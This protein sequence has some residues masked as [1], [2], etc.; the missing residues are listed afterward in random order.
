MA[1]SGYAWGAFS[2]G[3]L[4]SVACTFFLG[5][6]YEDIGVVTEEEFRGMGLSVACAGALCGD[7]INR[8]HRPSWT[9]WADNQASIRVAEKLGFTLNRRTIHYLIGRKI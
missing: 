6:R 5:E 2:D 9:T 7:I 4:A 3:R 8:G 1:A